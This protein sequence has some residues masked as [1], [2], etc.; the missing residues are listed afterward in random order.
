M[1]SLHPILGVPHHYYVRV[2][3]AVDVPLA[4]N[5][6]ASFTLPKKFKFTA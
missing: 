2:A 1:I 4:D 3:D 5:T 6:G